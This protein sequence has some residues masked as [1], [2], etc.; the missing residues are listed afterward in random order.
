MKGYFTQRFIPVSE[1]PSIMRK[2]IATGAMGSLWGNLI[3]GIVYVYFG[4]AIGMNR[5]QWGVLGAISAWVIMAQPI[6]AILGERSGS[7]KR[8]WYWFAVTDRTLRFLGIL[9]AFLLWRAG[10]HSAHLAF[11]VAICVGSLLGNIATPPWYGWLA[12]IIPQEVQ[13]S[14]WGRRD[15]WIS[16]AVIVVILPCGYIMDLIP[17]GGKLGMAVAILSA[18][19]FIGLADLAIHGTIPEPPMAANPAANSFANILGPLRD[20]GFRPWL[21]FNLC[22]N[23][24][25]SLG[26]AL[27]TL[28]FMENLGFKD[29]LLGGM[30]AVTA[31][32]LAA[33]MLTAR[34]GGRL[35][36][37][38]GF[39][40]VFFLSYSLWT[41][42]PFIWLLATPKTGVFWI[43]LAN[44]LFGAS[45]LAANNAGI[46]LVTRYPQPGESAMYMAV[47]SSVANL[48]AGLGS[49]AA[50]GFLWIVGGWSFALGGLVV[51]AFPLLFIISGVLRVITIVTLIPGIPEK[52]AVLME[53]RRLLLPIFFPLLRGGKKPPEN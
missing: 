16:L 43:G 31:T 42:L 9:G 3:T 38:W 5:F 40:R 26:G 45:S 32:A 41:L 48:A 35:V 33:G 51:S 24:S 23:F 11:M 39:R 25:Q 1:L 44:V 37:K 30:I 14:F 19:G 6:G 50:G 47:T 10:N 18:A 49:L 21:V 4:N 20:R 12:T 53:R 8:A 34:R 15:A 17:E 46:K 2:H 52:G 7:R 22:W 13:G 28:Y 36:D 27:C 29:N